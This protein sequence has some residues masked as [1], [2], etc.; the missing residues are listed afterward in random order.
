MVTLTF[1]MLGE[2][3]KSLPHLKMLGMFSHARGS[4]ALFRNDEDGNAYEIDIRPVDLGNFKDDWG[5]VIKKKIERSSFNTNKNEPLLLT[6]VIKIIKDNFGD[7][8]NNIALKS[9]NK[10]FFKFQINFKNDANIDAIQQ[11]VHSLELVDYFSVDSISLSEPNNKF[12]IIIYKK[13]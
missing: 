6:D 8:I 4:V 9:N 11:A 1:K 2:I 3:K 5:N 7:S 12:A 10:E 13:L